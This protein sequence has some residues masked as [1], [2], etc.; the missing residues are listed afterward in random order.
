MH[1]HFSKSDHD[2]YD[3]VARSNAKSFWARQGW[4]VEDNPDQ[5]GV[6]LIAEKDGKRF[7]LEVEVKRGWHGV[8]FKYDTIHLPVRK[9]KF[10]DRPTR[11]MVFNNS[12]THAAVISRKAVQNSPVSVVPNYKVPIG[13]KFFDVPVEDVT[14]VYTM[15]YT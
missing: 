7:Y 6:D 4:Q 15:E 1:K 10:L 13:E 8:D 3:E 2:K 14:F 12:L 5:Y 9:S 11:F